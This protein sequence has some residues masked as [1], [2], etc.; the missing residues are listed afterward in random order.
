[1]GKGIKWEEAC[2]GLDGSAQAASG[3]K[4]RIGGLCIKVNVFETLT[5]DFE[6]LLPPT[7]SFG[8]HVPIAVPELFI[9]QSWYTHTPIY[10]SLTIVVV[11]AAEYLHTVP[12]FSSSYS[13]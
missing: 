7:V 3:G 11:L 9:L 10:H 6:K 12:I 13:I 4:F 5:T 2:S 1:M 8:H